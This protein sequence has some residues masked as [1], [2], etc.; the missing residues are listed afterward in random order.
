MAK[1]VGQKKKWIERSFLII[2]IIINV[3]I[4][5]SDKTV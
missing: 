1:K 3:M 4:I 2:I 5:N